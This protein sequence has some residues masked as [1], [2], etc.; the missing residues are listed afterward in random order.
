MTAPKAYMW[1]DTTFNFESEV[2]RQLD[3]LESKI[4]GHDVWLMPGNSTL[5]PPP[6]EKE[7]FDR[8]W[9]KDTEEWE[10]VEKKKDPEPEP[11][12]PTELDLKRQELWENEQWLR[13]HDYVGTKIA[14]GRGT[15]EEYADVI[16][17]M[18]VKAAE[19]ERLKAEIKEMEEEEKA[20]EVPAEEADDSPQA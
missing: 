7:G 13:D 20:L 14:T 2:D 1:N 16:A 17:E 8:H 15:V 5:T 10:Y 3:P 11:Y 6:E 9:N 18:N 12:V 19:V 4:V